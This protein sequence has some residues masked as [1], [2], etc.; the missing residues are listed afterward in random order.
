MSRIVVEKSLMSSLVLIEKQVA[1]TSKVSRARRR[2]W[3][4]SQNLRVI[5][6]NQW[7]HMFQ[8][9][10]RTER[11]GLRLTERRFRPRNL[12]NTV[13]QQNARTSPLTN[14]QRQESPLQTLLHKFSP[15]TRPQSNH[16]TLITRG[17]KFSIPQS[18]ERPRQQY[19]PQRSR[20][21]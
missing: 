9:C 20:E 16:P 15:K 13:A 2:C 19:G 17:E 7:K 18:T 11:D 5:R 14:L 4:M 6:G 10:D 21:G 1:Y 12:K 8:K 3:S